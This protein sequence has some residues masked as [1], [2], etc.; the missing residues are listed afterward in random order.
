VRHRPDDPFA[1]SGTLR[2]EDVDLETMTDLPIEQDLGR[3]DGLGVN[4]TA[5]T[6]Q[7]SPENWAFLQRK[8]LDSRGF[9]SN[10]A[11]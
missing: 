9:F 7:Q 1:V 4:S 6:S 10:L 8:G 5:L 2:T 3:V 11:L